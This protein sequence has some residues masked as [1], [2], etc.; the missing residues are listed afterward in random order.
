MANWK[1][2]GWIS[3]ISAGSL[4]GLWL[5]TRG[6]VNKTEYIKQLQSLAARLVSV[7]SAKIHKVDLSGLTI[8][9]DVQL[10]NPTL[11]GFK[12]QYPFIKMQYAG[13]TI[14][15]S[16]PVNKTISIPPNGEAKIEAI[17]FN[18]PLR[19]MLTLIKSLLVAQQSGSAVKLDIVTESTID[20]LWY[21]NPKTGFWKAR[22]DYGFKQLHTIPFED[23]KEIT[24]KKQEDK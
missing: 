14:G 11:M 20:P 13:D 12:M 23:K 3:G 19:S 7:P 4:A 17:Y 21:V 2:I 10:K 24:L 15:S 5:L 9:V 22:S 18:F 16:S 1:K 6:V 8:R